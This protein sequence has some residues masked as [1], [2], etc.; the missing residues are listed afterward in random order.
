[1][2][3]I[4]EELNKLFPCE[5]NSTYISNQA[6]QEILR[7]A[8][9]G[10]LCSEATR[11]MCWRYLLG[12]ISN[13]DTSLWKE[14]LLQS[15]NVYHETKTKVMPS[16]HKA[17]VDPL[18]ALSS[19]DNM[20]DEWSSYYKNVE[21][22]NFI[23]GDLDRLYLNGLPD[24][25]FQTKER[26]EILLSILFIWSIQHHTISYRQGMHEILGTILY[27]VECERKAWE[28]AIQSGKIPFDYPLAQSFKLL[29][30]EPYT[31]VLFDRIM[32]ELEPLYDPMPV[33]G[34]E[35]QPFIVHYCTKIQ[36]IFLYSYYF[37]FKLTLFC[38][39]QL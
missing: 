32:M 16:L 33:T 15:T 13:Q 21:L 23:K 4:V 9:K 3:T 2:S 25:F 6:K 10:N 1:M 29:T 22:T 20:S 18:S 35:N 24:E 38:L 36:G 7:L 26:R 19:G 5:L 37:L 17:E 39:Y 31:Y 30:I 12:I 27:T 14:E 11:A 28:E 34:M 8:W